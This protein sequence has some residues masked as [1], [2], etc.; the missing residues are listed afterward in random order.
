MTITKPIILFLYIIALSACGGSSDDSTGINTDNAVSLSLQDLVTDTILPSDS[1]T[2]DLYRVQVDPNK[3]YSIDL[4][5]E[6]S[7]TSL[8]G[9][10]RVFNK[11]GTLLLPSNLASTLLTS[12]FEFSTGGNTEVFIEISI[13]YPSS[14]NFQYQLA[15]YPSTD[16]GLLQDSISFEPNNTLT[17]AHPL[18]LQQTINNALSAGTLDHRDIY[19]IDVLEGQTYTV[20]TTFANGTSTGAGTDLQLTVSDDLGALFVNE[21]S[22]A[23]AQTTYN[24]ITP[25]Q[26]GKL[27]IALYSP[28]VAQH[29]YYG[30]QL[31]V[32]PAADNGLIQDNLS[33]EPNN[34]AS[35]AYG[36]D[37][38]TLY[39]S[40]LEDGTEDH[41]DFYTI[42]VTAGETY[43]IMLANDTGMRIG[44][45]NFVYLTVRES[46]GTVLLDENAINNSSSNAFEFVATQDTQAVISLYPYPQRYA[47]SYLY[48]L[49]V[50]PGA[51]TLTQDPVSF[52]PNETPNIATPITLSTIFQ[53]EL[54]TDI[55]DRYDYFNVP[56]QNGV[57][58]QLHLDVV[59]EPGE[60]GSALKVSVTSPTGTEWLID[61]NVTGTGNV[62]DFTAFADSDALVRIE[63]PA[64]YLDQGYVYDLRIEPAP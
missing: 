48:R 6:N 49:L 57:D 15:I 9:H 41:M 37:L 12:Y 53:S 20:M 11:D 1:S 2:S 52:E 51:G 61:Q 42:D 30:Y 35:T 21:Q 4:F 56:V 38:E 23:Y 36:I 22:I 17:T 19:A 45:Y 28:R 29:R 33:F 8:P 3:T 34:S 47:D 50:T 16:N 13:E 58:Y 26:T 25:Q 44:A 43:S 32:V 60:I 5:I 27:Y 54:S 24:E 59:T 40:E 14:V 55:S 7:A 62:L 63:A 18:A 46:D 10:I 64:N 39:T 31:S